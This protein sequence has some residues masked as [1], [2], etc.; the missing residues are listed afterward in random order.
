MNETT[1]VAL[2]DRL[3][4]VRSWVEW[5]P[6]L[7]ETSLVAPLALVELEG[8]EAPVSARVLREREYT[9][10]TLGERGTT[11]YAL[12]LLAIVGEERPRWVAAERVTERRKIERSV[13][14][15]E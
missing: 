11:P 14:N 2:L 6:E 8:H 10:R 9:V 13:Y 15:G 4:S 7:I 3:Q 5:T 1:T 12:V